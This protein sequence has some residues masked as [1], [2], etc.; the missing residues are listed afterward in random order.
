MELGEL[1]AGSRIVFLRLLAAYPIIPA[2]VAEV[3]G[4]GQFGNTACEV[5]EH[6]LTLKASP[7]RQH[8]FVF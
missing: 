4:L 3:Y 7:L 8:Y 6:L 5:V 2:T 1:T